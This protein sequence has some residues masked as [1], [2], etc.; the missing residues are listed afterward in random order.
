MARPELGTKRLCPNCGAK[1]YD[2]NNDP[3][4]C[5]KC[6]AAFATGIVAIRRASTRAANREEETEAD[7]EG[8]ELVSLEEAEDENTDDAASDDEEE[9]TV[10][11]DDDV[12]VDDDSDE[13]VSDVVRG[14]GGDEEER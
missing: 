3:I 6:N 9:V 7:N 14:S 1:Y 11:A 4:M 2:L 12:L 8:V 5:P 13:E 10:N